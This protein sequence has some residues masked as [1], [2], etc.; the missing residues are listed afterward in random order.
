MSDI[1]QNLF[2]RVGRTFAVAPT[3]DVMD[4]INETEA[5]NDANANQVH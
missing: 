4:L 2:V 1:V 5:E 3:E